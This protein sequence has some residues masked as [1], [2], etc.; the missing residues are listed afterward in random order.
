[1]FPTHSKPGAVGLGSGGLA[2]LL[3][4]APAPVYALG[5]VTAS[6]FEVCLE[7]GCAGVAAIRGLR[8]ET[9][10]RLLD[11]VREWERARARQG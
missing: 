3:P 7:A 10:L 8:G 1:V 9:G 5:G 4:L 11:A 6:N 2:R